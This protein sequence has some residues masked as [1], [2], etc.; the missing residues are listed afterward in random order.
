MEQ[1]KCQEG[2]QQL[3]LQDLE[4]TGPHAHMMKCFI[5]AIISDM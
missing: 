5:K 2:G 3:S 4:H 1:Q